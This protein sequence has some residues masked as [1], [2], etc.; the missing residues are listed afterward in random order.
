ML[1]VVQ[2]MFGQ[3]RNPFVNITHRFHLGKRGMHFKEACFIY[4]LA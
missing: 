3:R 1:D 4:D 2:W